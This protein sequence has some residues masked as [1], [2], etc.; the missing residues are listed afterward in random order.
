MIKDSENFNDFLNEMEEGA[1]DL[2]SALRDYGYLLEDSDIDQAYRDY[3]DSRAAIKKTLKRYAK[4]NNL[5]Y[6]YDL[7]D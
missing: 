2:D 5:E 3:M 1:L 6:V 7:L 4:E